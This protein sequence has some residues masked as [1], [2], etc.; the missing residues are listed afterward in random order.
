MGRDFNEVMNYSEKREGLPINTARA[1][2]MWAMVN[3]CEMIDLGFK[4]VGTRG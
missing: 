1:N 4:V 2:D 3:Y